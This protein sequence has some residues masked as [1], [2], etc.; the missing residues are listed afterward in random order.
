VLFFNQVEDERT[1]DSAREIAALL[2]PGFRAG[3]DGIIAGSIQR[4]H[5]E[6]L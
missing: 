1:M 6:A 2:P 5:V 3:L 4:D